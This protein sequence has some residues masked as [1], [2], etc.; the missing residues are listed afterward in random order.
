MEEFRSIMIIIRVPHVCSS[1]RQA[2][3]GIDLSDELCRSILLVGVSYPSIVDNQ[4]IEKMN[5]F[6]RNFKVLEFDN[7][8][9]ILKKLFVSQ[10]SYQKKYSRYQ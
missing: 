4:F 3:Q 6:D 5:Y 1:K 2:Y 7:K 9:R 10:T 8:Q